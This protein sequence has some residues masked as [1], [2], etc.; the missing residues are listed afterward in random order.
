MKTCIYPGSFDPITNGHLDIIKRASKVFDK[1]VVCMMINYDKKST[2][3]IEKRKEMIAKS[4]K[5]ISNVEIDFFEGLLVDYAKKIE[6]SIIVRGLRAISDF[7]NELAMA[8]LNNSLSDDIE[9]IFF[10]SSTKHSFIS[11]SMI[12][13]VA[14]LGG[15]VSEFVPAEILDDIKGSLI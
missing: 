8:N 14:A 10:M 3:S 6:C 13:Q 5:D 12:R 7:E 11:S 15:D 9:T 4:T 1:V 2:F